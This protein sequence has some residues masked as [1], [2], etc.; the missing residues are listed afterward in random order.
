M[1]YIHHPDGHNRPVG[2]V[3]TKVLKAQSMKSK[4]DIG[5]TP[6]YVSVSPCSVMYPRYGLQIGI[7]V[8]DNASNAESIFDVA[9]NVASLRDLLS[10]R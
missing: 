7:S 6:V 2:S 10:D 5:G 8:V 3:L 9:Y 1:I 4:L